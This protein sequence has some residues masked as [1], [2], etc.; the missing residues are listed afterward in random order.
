MASSAASPR[1]RSARR[2]R[3]R[4]LRHLFQVR[5]RAEPV[6]QDRLALLGLC[7]GQSKPACKKVPE[8]ITGKPLNFRQWFEL[9]ILEPA[10]SHSPLPLPAPLRGLHGDGK[11]LV[12]FTPLR[13]PR[14]APCRDLGRIGCRRSNSAAP[15]ATRSGCPPAL[16]SP[17]EADRRGLREDLAFLGRFGEPPPMDIEFP[18]SH[19]LTNLPP[20][21]T[22]TGLPGHDG[23][24][25]YQRVVQNHRRDDRPLVRQR[26][27][28]DARPYAGHAPP[29]H[30]G[31]SWRAPRF[32]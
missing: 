17:H 13:V 15:T 9:R 16:R 10:S 5:H 22:C 8:W 25:R 1:R 12:D 3:P 32:S 6:G 23:R 29:A 31:R 11:P 7:R 27:P 4:G 30:A 26:C 21:A 2:R 24:D 18:R 14:R 19:R 28:A 20:S